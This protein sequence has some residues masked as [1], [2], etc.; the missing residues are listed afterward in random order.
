MK[1]G[2]KIENFGLKKVILKH[3][4]ETL[5]KCF[6]P[7]KKPTPSLRLWAIYPTTYHAI[8]NQLSKRPYYAS[9]HNNYMNF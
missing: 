7:P 6:P 4:E 2:H 9:H 5:K 3:F 1:K 8:I